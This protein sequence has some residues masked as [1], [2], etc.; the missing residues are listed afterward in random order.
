M[1][2]GNVRRYIGG[3]RPGKYFKE[4]VFPKHDDVFYKLGMDEVMGVALFR[5]F[6]KIDIDESS[7]VDVEEL[8]QHI[9]G[10]RTKFNERI[11]DMG[12]KID[13]EN[14]LPFGAFTVT[15]WNYCTYTTEMLA[16]Y[17]WEIFDIDNTKFLERPDIEAMYRMLYNCDDHDD[18]YVG[19]FPFN[20]D[21]IITRKDF[22]NHAAARRHLI[23]PAIDFQSRL[24]NRI[25]GLLMWNQLT[26]YRTKY[27]KV[28]DDESATLEEA[29]ISILRAENPIPRDKRTADEILEDKKKQVEAEI[30]AARI[31]LEMREKEQKREQE[32]LLR[33]ANSDERLVK[34]AQHEMESKLENFSKAIFTTDDVWQRREQRNDLFACFDTFWKINEEYWIRKNKKDLELIIGVPEDHEGNVFM[35]IIQFSVLNL[36]LLYQSTNLGC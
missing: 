21:E 24:Q 7:T 31:V 4:D 1:G 17:I 15:L 9:G 19:R 13:G 14:G 12:D 30:E 33:I 18:Y 34:I 8:F 25:G 27:F 26:R 3:K 32:R 11:F 16:R 22:I 23:Q 28:F 6:S 10:R 36:D 29:F 2:N 35:K 5:V 20:R